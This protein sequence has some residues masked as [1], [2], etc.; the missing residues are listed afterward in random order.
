MFRQIFY[1]VLIRF[2]KYFKNNILNTQPTA[3]VIIMNTL[4][5][6]KKNLLNRIIVK[7]CYIT[8]KIKISF[9]HT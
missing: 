6:K 8:A 5:K 1:N 3:S 7:G 9:K 4:K 2:Q